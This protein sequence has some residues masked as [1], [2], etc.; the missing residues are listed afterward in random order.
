VRGLAVA[1]LALVLVAS[2]G[3]RTAR[4]AQGTATIGDA[5][6]AL[7]YAAAVQL[8]TPGSG[9]YAIVLSSKPLHCSQLYNLPDENPIGNSW[10][11][12]SLFPTKDGAISTAQ[13]R[14]EVD[15]PLGDAYATLSRGVSIRVTN[16]G[17]FSGA[18]WRGRVYQ[19]ARTV[20]GN[21]YAVKAR[22]SAQLCG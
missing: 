1:A 2:A 7:R 12:V 17:L 11:L 18:V 4:S 10:V 22:F 8:A 9:G 3:A 20:E 16:F 21:V 15:Y 6:V 13:V 5:K 19:G 14:G